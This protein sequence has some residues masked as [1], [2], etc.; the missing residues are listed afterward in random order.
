MKVRGQ[1]LR[2]EP[3]QSENDLG[4]LMQPGNSLGQSMQ[5]GNDS[6]PLSSPEAPHMAQD[7]SS[8]PLAM[9]M[10]TAIMLCQVTF[11][12]AR[13]LPNPHL[14]VLSVCL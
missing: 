12:F 13:S 7:V 6:A 4:V 10:H 14:D 3:L 2:G 9:K 8:Y 11:T 1:V 5:L